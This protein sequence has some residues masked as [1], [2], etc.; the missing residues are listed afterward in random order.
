M[1]LSLA[2][3]SSPVPQSS[4]TFRMETGR[5]VVGRGEDCDWHLDDPGMFMSRQH[6]SIEATDRGWTVTDT[7]SGGLF[8]DEGPQPLGRGRTA[9][10]RD[11]MRLRLGDVVV[12]VELSA[13]AQA[14]AAAPDPGIGLDPFFAPREVPPP[15]PRPADLPEPFERTATPVQPGAA[16]A[17][18][19]FDDPFTLDPVPAAQRPASGPAGPEDLGEDKI[20]GDRTG[21]DSIEWDWGPSAQTPAARTAGPEPLTTASAEP[22]A[23]TAESFAAAPDDGT[24]A[25]LRGAGLDPAGDDLPDLEAVGR[26]YRMMTEGIVALLRARSEEKTALR[27]P[28]T[29]LGA[30]QVNPLK[31]LVMPDE[32]VAA[33]IAPRGGGYLDPDTAIA[34]AFRDLA[35]HR[36]RSW[37]GLQAALRRMVDRFAPD[38]IEAELGDP[39]P[40][41]TLRAGGRGALLWQAYVERWAEIAHAAE[42]RFLGEIG[43]EFRDTYENSDR[44]EP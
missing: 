22:L 42:D 7:S 24:A 17:L 32:Q 18:P 4:D 2:V 27:V 1:T 26:R 36:M 43:A 29:L 39:S 33:L 15:P 11:G 6:C 30:Q 28:P 8:L 34:E 44:R 38:A 5:A 13:P 12:G 25:F 14:G 3:L 10:L 35:D 19:G 16:D 40:L 23:P 21:L 20:G 9:L 41:R 37:Q 31:F